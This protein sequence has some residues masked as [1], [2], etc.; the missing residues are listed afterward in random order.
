MTLIKY[1]PNDYVPGTFGSFFDRFFNDDYF[2]GSSYSPTVDV[3]ETEKEFEIQFHLPGMK[4][5]NISI[6][7][8]NDRLTVSGERKFENEK[9][10]KNYHKV[11]SHYGTFSRSFYLPDTVN[12]EKIDASY[13]DGILTV[14]VPKDGKKE[15]KRTISIK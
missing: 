5:E 15:S 9:K 3:A 7:V 1:K 6:N 12:A 8:D 2:N 13:K 11:E 14:T 4:K 10:D